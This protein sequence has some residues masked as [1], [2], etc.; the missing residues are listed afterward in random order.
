MQKKDNETV[1]NTKKD[2]LNLPL[3]TYDKCV[4]RPVL[5]TLMQQ[6]QRTIADRYRPVSIGQ[7]ISSSVNVAIFKSA[8]S[9][10]ERTDLWNSTLISSILKRLNISLLSCVTSD[11][12]LKLLK[13]NSDGRCRHITIH[14]HHFVDVQSKK[15]RK[16]H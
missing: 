16:C 7:N 11:I 6:R 14:F 4:R 5:W 2:R 15:R 9:C 10:P 3:D 12:I 8:V 13:T 1:V